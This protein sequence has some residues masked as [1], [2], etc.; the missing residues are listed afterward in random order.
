MKIDKITLENYRCFEDLEMN[1]NSK[2]NIIIGNNGGGK[3]TVLDAIATLLGTISTHLPSISGINFK[4]N[5]ITETEA[6][7]KPYTRL[8]IDMDNNISW[9]KIQRRDK[10][11]KTQEAIPKGIGQK[12]IKEYLDNEV[13]NKLNEDQPFNLPLFVYY[14]VNRAILDLPLTRKGFTERGSRILALENSLDATSRFRKAFMWFYNKENEEFRIQKE[15]RSFDETLK[16]L[17]I[18]R[19]AITSMFPNISK[20]H[21]ETNPL[22]FTVTKD[23]QKQSIEQL[24]DG[25]KTMLGL[26]IDLSSRFAMANPHLDNP[27]EAEA[28]VMID[29]IDLHLHP[30]W[31]KRVLQD[32]VTL[33]PN[34]QFIVT[35]HSPYIVESLNNNL[36]KS[37]IKDFEIVSDEINKIK[38]I[39]KSEVRVYLLEDNQKIDILDD[40]YGL[41][42][43]RLL[44]NFNEINNL[45]DKMREIEIENR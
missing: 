26:V 34:T 38:P 4:K 10:S 9:D 13:I 27:L 5:D 14:G 36:K 44:N 45:Y 31:Q 20:P 41:V 15:K 11:T 8:S 2:V 24:S 1:F 23:N 18:V 7:Q 3:T 29:E 42:D 33:F 22:R 25:Y 21:I 40:E 43:D 37:K 17:D 32:L 19:N 30:S 16:E 12:E 35:T 6:K 28:I 39:D